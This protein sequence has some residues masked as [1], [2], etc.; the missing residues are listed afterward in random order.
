VK[1]L[2]VPEEPPWNSTSIIGFVAEIDAY[3][4]QVPEV[5]VLT[6]VVDAHADVAHFETTIRSPVARLLSV[7]LSD[8]EEVPDGM[9]IQRQLSLA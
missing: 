5:K 4:N 6:D 8:T 2:K 3:D 9:I 1:L 7:M